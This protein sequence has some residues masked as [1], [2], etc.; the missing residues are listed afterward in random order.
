[1]GAGMKRHGRI[2]RVALVLSVAC[3]IAGLSL[4]CSSEIVGPEFE[5]TQT[6]ALYT[7]IGD[8]PACDILAFRTT[9]TGLSMRDARDPEEVA[10]IISTGTA[11]IK[12]D[13]AAFRDIS[14]IMNVATAPVA[15]YDQLNLRVFNLQVVVYDPTDDPPVRNI[16]AVFTSADAIAPLPS[17]FSIVGDSLNV[18]RLDF[19]M[20]RSVELDEQG[21]MTGNVTP[22]L[23]ATP[24]VFA[25]SDG[26]G[27]F[28]NLIGFVRA[29]S[30]NPSSAFLGNFT[31]QL[32]SG[33]GPAIF[34]NVNG[35]TN[36][37][38]V[39]DLM[40]L[41]TGRVVEVDAYVDENGTV[42]ARNVEVEDRAI[43]EEQRIAF[44]GKVLPTPTRDAD[45]N[46][47]QF[48]LY[49]REEEP[50]VAVD[51]PLDSIVTVNVP[52]SANF[53]ISSRPENFAS[54]LFDPRSV[55]IG[56]ELIVHGK[57]TLTEGEPT[58]VDASSIY[59]RLQ[60]MQGGLS[61]L[62][63]VGNDGRTGAF[64][65]ETCSGLLAS[66]PVIVLTNNET[67]FVNVFGLSEIDPQRALLIRGLPFY[68]L[69]D[70]SYNGI[71]LPA[72]S[73]VFVANQVHQ[74]Q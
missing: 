5:R 44:I 61:S 50:E 17:G 38:G 51:V 29:V 3:L 55:A 63:D 52:A 40:S 62:V 39:P 37:H 65:L 9:V 42:I 10:S 73:V 32:L 6:G 60:T 33:S 23:T 74:L 31:M 35:Q 53:Q 25:E 28:D 15:P 71:P 7:Y 72:G 34:I 11:S 45:G 26:Y 46:V 56:Q 57:Y 13:L 16:N 64:W 18:L 66:A 19:D 4:S 69:N 41:E 12:V 49:V 14:T 47:T 22:V 58:V 30:P 24:V 59:L 20:L 48:Q 54:V 8:A 21:Q 27:S 70:G 2:A 36:M 1:M 67:T 43:V 68:Q